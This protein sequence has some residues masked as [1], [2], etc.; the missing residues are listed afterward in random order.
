MFVQL[1]L[2]VQKD[3]E[4]IQSS[5]TPDTG[6]HIGKWQKHKKH[7]KEESQEVSPFLVGDQKATT[8]RHDS[9]ADMKHK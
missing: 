2:L 5:T 1:I 3:Q 8:N 6:H 4:L 7:H 9:M